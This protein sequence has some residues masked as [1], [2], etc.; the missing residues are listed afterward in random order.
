MLRCQHAAETLSTDISTS[1]ETALSDTTALTGAMSA[2]YVE[3]CTDEADEIEINAEPRD[4]YD[5]GR[6]Y[7]PVCIGEVLAKRYRIVHK[8]GFGGFSTVWMAYDMKEGKDVALKILTQGKD[9]EKEYFAQDDIIR[10][11]RDRSN[12][13]TFHA[14][15][16][17]RGRNND[18][19]RVLVLPLMGP[20][21]EMTRLEMPVSTHMSFRMSAA[22]QLLVA[23]KG[24][25]DAGIVHQGKPKP[26]Y[27]LS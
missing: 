22:R 18:L 1:M 26:F 13:V 11:V 20:N 19:Y 14:T 24:L 10:R 23:L 17:L 6:L 16:Q 21:L 4:R 5:S 25:H 3:W 12:L 15:F 2:D 9:G 27:Y 7:Y 8:L